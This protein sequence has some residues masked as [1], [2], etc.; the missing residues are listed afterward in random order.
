[1]FEAVGF[2]VAD[3]LIIGFI[4]ASAI[5]AMLR[6]FVQEVLRIVAWVLAVLAAN[7]LYPLVKPLFEGWI[8]PGV[9]A[10]IL[11]LIVPFIS[12]LVVFLVVAVWLT[13]RIKDRAPIPF[14][15]S[16]GFIWGAIRGAIILSI[17]YLGMIL[18]LG[19]NS[20]PAWLKNSLS[21]AYLQTGADWVLT[22]SPDSFAERGR[23][24]LQQ[25]N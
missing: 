3:L 12:L 18:V 25:N 17:V 1:M 21:H 7:W 24:L 6:G 16:L 15:H 19:A 9:G 2:S 22:V 11:G 10:N 20:E 5:F 8:G 14:D 23:E 13:Y 4:L